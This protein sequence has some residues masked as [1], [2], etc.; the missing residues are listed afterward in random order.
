MKKPIAILYARSEDT[1][2][3]ENVDQETIASVIAALPA[4]WLPRVFRFHGYSTALLA[5]LESC[6]LVIDLCYGYAPKGIDQVDVVQWLN[7]HRMLH[8][9]S[10]DQAMRLAQDKAVLPVLCAEL[11]LATPALLD[12][13]HGLEPDRMYLLKPRFGSCHRGM[14]IAG[15]RELQAW[16]LELDEF[17]LL[18]P[19]L[20]GRE[21]SVAVV[22]GLGGE[23]LTALPPVELR[24]D[25]DTP[26]FVPGQGPYHTLRDFDPPLEQGFRDWIMQAALALHR[27]IGLSCLSRTDFRMD[28]DGMP[29]V[30]DV[31]ALP[32]M[33]PERSLLPAICR[34]AG[35]PLPE[36]MGRILAFVMG[37]AERDV[38]KIRKAHAGETPKDWM[39][40]RV[41]GG[42]PLP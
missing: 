21:F 33:H 39:V 20:S 42:A 27:R 31:N 25:R 6:E 23:G 1:P 26:V 9:G 22:P 12:P 7:Q 18:Q 11:G 13:E 38:L 34:H 29:H 37:S 32:N 24:P 4:G 5:E 10:S 17:Q 35:I 16:P 36:L 14:K 15:G 30:L 8:T 3:R 19:Y 41:D 2:W 28:Q 40:G